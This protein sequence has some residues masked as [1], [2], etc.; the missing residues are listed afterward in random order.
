MTARKSK[1]KP[2]EP[3]E[4]EV[5]EQPASVGIEVE[6]VEAEDG[7]VEI[8]GD[9]Q[10]YSLTMYLDKD[11]DQRTF[12]D[13]IR[14]TERLVR[15]NPDYKDWVEWMRDEKGLDACA[16]LTNVDVHRA[17]IQLHHAPSN[18]FQICG[19]VANRIVSEG[20]KAS[21]F[22]VA[23]EVLKLHFEGKV[24][25]V[26]LSSTVHELVHG[27][28]LEIPSTVI[29]G[30]WEAYAEEYGPWMDDYEKGELESFRS[31]PLLEA[32]ENLKFLEYQAKELPGGSQK[33]GR[34]NIEEE[35]E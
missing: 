7:N 22:M 29:H 26:P 20:G 2:E 9:Q 25:I 8:I 10:P 35:E 31:R 32:P 21:T 15:G 23:D 24:G 12:V 27:G 6:E 17:E 33:T 28:K 13:F 14:K 4:G 5:S 19:T 1:R 30:D 16:F 11:T 34:T 18:L 3:I